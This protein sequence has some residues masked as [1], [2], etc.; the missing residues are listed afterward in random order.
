MGWAGT[1]PTS[2]ATTAAMMGGAHGTRPAAGDSLT[3]QA[4]RGI[5]ESLGGS[6]RKR[7]GSRWD[8]ARRVKD[9]STDVVFLSCCRKFSLNPGLCLHIRVR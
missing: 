5:E 9:C 3:A 6:L 2:P 1:W 4:G 7:S 8:E